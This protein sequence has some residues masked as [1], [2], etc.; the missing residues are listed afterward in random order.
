MAEKAIVLDEIEFSGGIIGAT[1]TDDGRIWVSV[2]HLCDALGVDRGGQRL[3]IENPGSPFSWRHMSLTG[4]DGKSYRMLCIENGSVQAW[5]FNINPSKVAPDVKPKLIKAQRE[6]HDIIWNHYN[7][8]GSIVAVDKSERAVDR[9]L[10]QFTHL[11]EKSQATYEQSQA[12]GRQ[13][14]LVHSATDQLEKSQAKL[15]VRT[16]R[17]EREIY[18]IKSHQQKNSKRKVSRKLKDD[19]VDFVLSV[20]GECPCCFEAVSEK[21]ELHVDHHRQV[22]D[23][24]DCSVW[25]ICK[26]CNTKALKDPNARAEAEPNFKVYQKRRAA[27]RKALQ[28]ML[29]GVSA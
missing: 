9:F 5:L 27:H 3:K 7:G 22:S 11:L 4:V 23:V 13:L 1:R 24:R 6:V 14:H 12:N 16:E 19:H 8:R 17:M 18:E 26:D 15:Q 21:H 29:P 20:L 25:A 2:S 28:P 10:D